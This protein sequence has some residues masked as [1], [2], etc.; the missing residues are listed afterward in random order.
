[1][2]NRRSKRSTRATCRHPC[3]RKKKKA[4]SVSGAYGTRLPEFMPPRLSFLLAWDH[5]FSKPISRQHVPVTP[6]PPSTR[7]TARN[8]RRTSTA[9]H[10]TWLPDRH[11]VHV[12][13][14][15]LTALAPSPSPLRTPDHGHQVQVELARSPALRHEAGLEGAIAL[16]HLHGRLLVHAAPQQAGH[17][18]QS[19]WQR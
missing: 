19:P 8:G 6:I 7:V 5:P 16:I 10:A 2:R 9:S 13:P 3:D 18:L 15:T 17:L 1:M 12:S 14:V 11:D 4:S